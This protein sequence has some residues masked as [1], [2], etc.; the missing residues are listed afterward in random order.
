MTGTE[1]PPRVACIMEQV[2]GHVAHDQT[3]RRVLRHRT[4]ITPTWIPVTYDGDGFIERLPLTAAVRSTARGAAQ[5]RAGLRRA[6]PDV[7]FFHTQKP[8]VFHPDL[9][10]RYPTVL[11]LDVTPRQYDALGAFYDHQP[12]LDGPVG[13]IKHAINRQLFHA[14]H[15]VVAW[16]RWVKMSLIADYGVDP[17]RVAVIPPGIDLELW[18]PPPDRSTRPQPRVLFVGGDFQRKGGDH[19]LDWFQNRGA[20]HC[21]LDIV[22]R[23]AVPRIDGLRVHRN[24][25]PNS[26][27][28]RALFQEADIFVLPS[29]GECFG[30][31]AIEAMAAGLPV[32]MTRVGGA[33]DIVDQGQ[34]GWLIAPNDQAA[35]AHALDGLVSDSTARR[36]MGAAAREKAGQAFNAATNAGRLA[37]CLRAAAA[38]GAARAPSPVLARI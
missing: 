16:S 24:I 13:W 2:L 29:L 32:V 21:E 36:A 18:G 37:E 3:L 30:I 7:L 22:T 14:A 4:D 8:A 6:Q 11:S 27:A 33:E 20:A 35:L 26:P 19:L 17:E 9:I 25:T 10:R 1:S 34:N 38:T 5:V 15:T 23:S 28:I 31:A 12:D